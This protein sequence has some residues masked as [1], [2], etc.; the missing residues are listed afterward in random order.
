[1]M[2]AVRRDPTGANATPANPATPIRCAGRHRQRGVA[3]LLIMMLVGMS[4]SAAVLGSAYYIRGMQVQSVSAH[5][6]TQAQMKAWTA[7]EIVRLYLQQ[8]Q[9][10]AMLTP[11]LAQAMP[12]ALDMKGDGATGLMSARITSY[13]AS[14]SRVTVEVIG[15]TAPGTRAEASSSLQVTFST[16][17][18]TTAPAPAPAPAQQCVVQPRS[19]AT[20][21]GDLSITGGETSITSPP[22]HSDIAVAGKL[23]IS[24]A[25]QAV[26]SGCAKGDISLSGG[27]ID[28]NATLSSEGRISIVSMSTPVNATL[29]AREINI[30][31]TGNGR[32]VAL[33]A[34]AYS[35]D[36]LSAGSTIGTTTLGGRLIPASAGN[37]PWTTGTVIP[38][39]T[40]SIVI[41]LGKGAKGTEYLLDLSKVAIVQGTGGITGASSAT[42]L[43]GTD[44][45]PDSLTFKAQSI[46]G[47]SIGIYTLTVG[48]VWGNEL[49]LLGYGGEYTEVL[50][51]AGLEIVDAKVGT[52]VGGSSVR[53]T[54]GG[55]SAPAT[56]W[57][58]PT[59][60][61]GEIAGK[62]YYGSSG[63]NVRTAFEGLVVNKV[64]TTPGLP[65]VPYCDTRG[66]AIDADAYKS[67]A[68][69]V[70]EFEKGRH[71]LTIQHVKRA[72]G[73]SIAGVYDLRD[74]TP[75]HKTLLSE[76]MTCD[77]GNNAGCLQNPGNSWSFSG[78]SRFSP[79]VLWFDGPVTFNGT[80]TDLLNS[81]I[82][83]GSVTLTSSGHRALTA[84]NF[85]TPALVCDGAFYP[86]NLCNKATSPSTFAVW[87]D[88]GGVSRTG[89][90]IANMALMLEE[91][92]N[93]SGWSING[94]VALGGAI[95]T[96]GA[97]TEIKGSVSA[98]ANSN[99][100][101]RLTEGGTK[102]I[103]T[104]LTQSQTFIPA[105]SCTSAST[106]TPTPTPT[107]GVRLLWSRYL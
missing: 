49:N 107:G 51:N 24:N 71:L 60:T 35:A 70:F 26:I 19:A 93:S 78:V 22:G 67:Q 99:A 87:N 82:G 52:L 41:K 4:L 83:K 54:A 29:W 15:V 100:A 61:K 101:T 95:A 39:S 74:P 55:F 30:A 103:T 37:I 92:L 77:Y 14:S 97:A 9:A 2:P 27:G 36:V 56:Y 5:A 28:A 90:P 13:Q 43:S 17:G 50:A 105:G 44:E 64:N 62:L 63:N 33:K 96:S 18:T 10:A 81:I 31:N 25:S 3:T 42:R 34:G 59:I 11:F 106:P 65:G 89:L 76:L 75:A 102:I 88:A 80:Q 40:G 91:G 47:G 48:Q 20:F 7:A 69:F 94:N 23:T 79:G 104:Q 6:Q 38:P 46:H 85:S 68:N 45:L 8:L 58:F 86:S 32:Y 12:I 21:G 98:G 1:M 16:A 72:N 53:A 66:D 73:E 57:N 84:P